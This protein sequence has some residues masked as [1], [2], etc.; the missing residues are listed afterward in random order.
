MVKK[1]LFRRIGTLAVVAAAIVSAALAHAGKL[2]N[3]AAIRVAPL[4]KGDVITPKSGA[5]IIDPDGIQETTAEVVVSPFTLKAVVGGDRLEVT[6]PG[7][8]L[9]QVRWE[10]EPIGCT[11]D[12]PKTKC[13]PTWGTEYSGQAEWVPVSVEFDTGSSSV[14]LGTVSLLLNLTVVDDK[15][16]VIDGYLAITFSESSDL[17][18]YRVP[19]TGKLK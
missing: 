11:D 17:S 4:S 14:E 15:V 5:I 12:D 3:P 13:Q 16:R 8:P 10:A 2:D 19:V 7:F 9:E 18:N 1:C 6:V